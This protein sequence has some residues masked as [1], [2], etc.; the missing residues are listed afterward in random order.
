MSTQTFKVSRSY[1]THQF[2]NW[3]SQTEE[4]IQTIPIPFDVKYWGAIGNDIAD[5]TIPIQKALDA[6]NTVYFPPGTYKITSSLTMTGKSNIVLEGSNATLDGSTIPALLFQPILGIYG[7]STSTANTTTVTANI[8]AG[9]VTIT[10]AS[11]SDIAIGDVLYIYS[12]TN[13]SN[14]D[15]ELWYTDNTARNN[16]INFGEVVKIAGNVITLDSQL[17]FAM[18]ATTY[19]VTAQI[20]KPA[21]NIVISGLTFLGAPTVNATLANGFGLNG[22]ELYRC[23]NVNINDCIFKWCQGHSMNVAYSWHLRISNCFGYG[24]P[25]GFIYSD[26]VEGL[27][28]GYYFAFFQ[29][30]IYIQMENCQTFKTRHTMDG[31]YTGEVIVMGNNATDNHRSA[32]RAH[33]GVYHYSIIGNKATGL[34]EAVLNSGWTLS[35]CCNNH[36]ITGGNAGIVDGDPLGVYNATSQGSLAGVCNI[37]NNTIETKI[38]Q[39]DGIR[40]NNYYDRV[41][42]EGNYMT[43]VTQGILC[44][45]ILI[46]AANINNN[47]IICTGVGFSNAIYFPTP[48]LFD[49][50]KNN[51]KIH[52]N[53]IAG[54]TGQAIRFFGAGTRATR[55]RNFSIVDNICDARTSP[56]VVSISLGVG[57]FGTGIYLA[58]NSFIGNT[59]EA[60]S[61]GT[62]TLFERYPTV[63]Y[64]T[65]ID[66]ALSAGG[67]NFVL[68]NA[69]G[70]MPTGATVQKGAIIQNSDPDNSESIGWVATNAGT[71]GTLVGVTATTNG[72]TTIV[73]VGNTD[74]KVYVGSWITVNATNVNVLT[75]SADFATITV[76]AVVAAAGPGAAVVYFNPV[77]IQYGRIANTVTGWTSTT[78]ASVPARTLAT[79]DNTA[80]QLTNALKQ[81]IADLSSVGV[82]NAVITP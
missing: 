51:I 32:Y 69:T 43:G 75:V 74:A 25:D 14:A 13:E 41:N 72:T 45:T 30:C 26:F 59:V 81:L 64:G 79:G 73:L 56:A 29:R 71:A 27:G 10:V 33:A 60:I 67:P 4:L 54:Y 16:R 19:V 70:V 77:F 58:D 38:T 9:A 39:T 55:V 61:I 82:I 18:D 34:V 24:Y 17:F 42:I 48:S 1:P 57:Y 62:A 11:A 49:V 31:A 52:S 68:R 8:A 44:Q 47:H 6:S 53:N 23:Y 76:S 50:A 21:K 2:Q 46:N 28:T 36:F 63:I 66:A 15:G 37:S 35:Q 12:G 3:I 20:I 22:L 80:A 78:G 40:L 7:E 5:D 65:P